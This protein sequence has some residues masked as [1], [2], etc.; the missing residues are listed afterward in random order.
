MDMF[1]FSLL[2]GQGEEGIFSLGRIHNLLLPKVCEDFHNILLKAYFSVAI[3][4]KG[5]SCEGL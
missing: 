3:G 5:L 2:S 4:L 1:K